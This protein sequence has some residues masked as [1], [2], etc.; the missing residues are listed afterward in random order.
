MSGCH[1]L[2]GSRTE[3]DY[4]R[5]EHRAKTSPPTTPGHYYGKNAF[6]F[7]LKVCVVRVTK[8]NQTLVASTNGYFYP[9]DELEWYGPVND[10]IPL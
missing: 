8:I 4:R 9:L 7:R 10:V 2:D 3:G 1:K 6:D 5:T